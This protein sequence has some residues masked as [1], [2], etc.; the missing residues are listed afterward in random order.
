[1]NYLDLIVVL[2]L[3]WFAFQ[4][5]RKGLVVEVASLAALILGI[6]AAVYFSHVTA[7]FLVEYF[8]LTTKYLHIIAIILTFLLVV[9]AVVTVG[10]I[11]EKFVDLILLGF[12]NK[13]T[14]AV[15]GILKGAVILSLIIW[16]FNYFDS[17]QKLISPQTRSSAMLFEHVESIAPSLYKRLDFLQDIEISNP[18]TDEE[19][20]PII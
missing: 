8:S 1:M 7:D 20:N 3:A 6:Y 11:V 17:D 10:R 5:Y 14:G 12:L 19:E 16:V 2:L 18:F 13:L 9:I 15:F 4:G